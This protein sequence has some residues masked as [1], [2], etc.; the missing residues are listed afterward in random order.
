MSK[1]TTHSLYWRGI[2]WRMTFLTRKSIVLTFA[3][4]NNF[5]KWTELKNP[6]VRMVKRKGGFTHHCEKHTLGI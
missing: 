3:K 2:Q 4:L 1:I 6:E 5:N